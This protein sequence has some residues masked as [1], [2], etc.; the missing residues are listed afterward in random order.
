MLTF[1]MAKM[2]A[3]RQSRYLVT[4]APPSVPDQAT[5]PQRL[6]GA[7]TGFL[8]ALSIFG[9]VSLLVAAIREHARI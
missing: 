8:M 2:E 3:V 5:H 7:L 9:I 1:E 6:L 4:I